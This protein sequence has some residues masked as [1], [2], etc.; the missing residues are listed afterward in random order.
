MKLV[1]LVVKK[2]P[3]V[4]EEQII[5]FTDEYKID[6]DFENNSLYIE[7][8][9]EYVK[10][11]YDKQIYN[12]SLIAGINGTGKSS[13]LNMLIHYDILQNTRSMI[14]RP[15]Y[16]IVFKDKAGVLVEYTDGFLNKD[17]ELS[18]NNNKTYSFSKQR[19]N[20]IHK[21]VDNIENRNEQFIDILKEYTMLGYLDTQF[22]EKFKRWSSYKENLKKENI[23]KR[24]YS[25]LAPDNIYKTFKRLYRRKIINSNLTYKFDMRWENI[26]E[27]FA[28]NGLRKKACFEDIKNFCEN[29]LNLDM[30]RECN[31]EYRFKF[32]QAI[33]DIMKSSNNNTM[34][35]LDPFQHGKQNFVV[36]TIMCG[37]D[38]INDESINILNEIYID[39]WTNKK[40][41][42]RRD[43]AELELSM[44]TGEVNIIAYVSQ[45]N[46]IKENAT[47]D[48]NYIIIIDEPEVG[49]HLEWSRGFIDFIVSEVKENEDSTKSH[50]FQ[51]IFTTHSPFMLSDI[52]PDNV[53]SLEKKHGKTVV[54]EHTNTFAKNI[55]EI[56]NDDMF[57]SNIYGDFAL[58]KINSLIKEL[59][60][61]KVENSETLLKEI[62][63]IS[64]P[65]LR[66]KL[67]DMYNQKIDTSED[68]N[69]TL[70]DKMNLT[71]EERQKI[72]DIL[73]KKNN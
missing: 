44:S 59:R 23:I 65:I 35:T 20:K 40:G 36:V 22:K 12:I 73:D 47:P 60:E 58:S 67:L 25:E 8:N 19:N 11:F 2:Y 61:E 68:L 43:I 34:V 72:L 38:S 30:N 9:Q 14:E 13:I 29:F 45:I 3:S 48:R 50:S 31:E 26:Y 42:R 64:E 16:C 57:I 21:V 28:N 49:M 69:R 18:I 32:W 46:Q 54:K 27:I 37:T 7:N 17:S 51:F 66:N 33:K 1:A 6:Y 56:M 53:I 41:N 52:K 55:Q 70:L 5:K 39:Y 71:T 63:M 10:D 62:N 15:T 24:N 4:F